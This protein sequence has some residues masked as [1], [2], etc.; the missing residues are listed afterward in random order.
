MKAWFVERIAKWASMSE[1]EVDCDTA[2]E[3][4]QIDSLAIVSLCIEIEDHFGLKNTDPSL[5]SEHNT[6]NK[7]VSWVETQVR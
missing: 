4:Y 5:L 1:A 7:L 6:I 3:D 2:F